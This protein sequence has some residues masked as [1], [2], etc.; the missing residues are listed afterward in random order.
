MMCIFNTKIVHDNVFYG[1]SKTACLERVLIFSYGLKQSQ[2]I[3]WQYSLIIIISG[4]N[5]SIPFTFSHVDNRQGK[6]RS[7]T[8]IFGW[9]WLFVFHPVMFKDYLIINFCRKNQLIFVFFAQRFSLVE[10]S[11]WDYHF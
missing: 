5:Q 6:L 8:V 9:M 2:W 1:S 11:T 4:R 3:I 10:G 7:I